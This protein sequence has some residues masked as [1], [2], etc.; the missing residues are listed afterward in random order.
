[1][2]ASLK[3]IRSQIAII[4]APRKTVSL[5]FARNATKEK[6]WPMFQSTG[7]ETT[8]TFRIW[9][10]LLTGTTGLR[11]L[12]FLQ[13]APRSNIK[14][15]IYNWTEECLFSISCGNFCRLFNLMTCL[16]VKCTIS[17]SLLRALF[18]YLLSFVISY[19]IT[20]FMSFA[21]LL[22]DAIENRVDTSRL[23]S[24]VRLAISQCSCHIL[25]RQYSGKILSRLGFLVWLLQSVH[26]EATLL[27]VFGMCCILC[28]VIPGIELWLAC[29][30]IREDYKPSQHP[31]VLTFS[32]AFFV[33]ILGWA[34]LQILTAKFLYINFCSATSTR[35]LKEKGKGK[36]PC[37]ILV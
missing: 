29:R 32:L 28:C 21:D 13:L 1:M 4:A 9:R 6:S 26:L 19:I 3:Q 24:E 17:K 10:H 22:T 27:V 20:C 11:N 31:S 30:P 18:T 12:N 33:C 23:I 25:L 2:K 35:K 7:L 5:F 16:L 34:S 36:E 14:W 15:Q 37:E 8:R